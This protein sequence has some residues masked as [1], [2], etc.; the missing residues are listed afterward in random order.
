MRFTPTQDEVNF[1]CRITREV[2]SGGPCPAAEWFIAN[3][4]RYSAIVAWQYWA[5]VNLDDY[6]AYLYDESLPDLVLPWSSK[7]EFIAR[8][9]EIIEQYPWLKDAPYADPGISRTECF[10]RAGAKIHG[11]ESSGRSKTP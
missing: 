5:Q 11:P 10:A 4:I 3:D 9:H 7:E 1:T 6:I 8:T 2:G